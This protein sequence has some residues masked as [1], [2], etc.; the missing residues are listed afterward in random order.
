MSGIP[1]VD[2]A[3]LS[4]SNRLAILD[5]AGPHLYSELLET[6]ARYAGMLL[7]GS[8]DLEEKRVA[9]LVPPT[10]EYAAVQWGIW[11]AGGIAVPLCTQ[12]PAPELAYSITDSDAEIV[13]AHPSYAALLEPVA[14][15]LG[16]RFLLTTDLP[17][18]GAEFLP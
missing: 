6:S 10:F 14:K 15:E 7:Q 18:A 11:R 2:R 17:S 8:H 9:Y 3:L 12:H 16:R 1:I 13:I 4:H 5:P